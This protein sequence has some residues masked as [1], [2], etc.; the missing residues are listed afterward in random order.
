MNRLVGCLL[1]GLV[2]VSALTQAEEVR[3]WQRL[4]LAISLVVGQERVIF[5][6]QP[7]RVGLPAPL[8]GRLRVQSAGGALYLLA[9]ETL[10]PTRLQVQLVESGEV[11][12]LDIAAEP[13]AQPL[14]PVRIAL[15]DTTMVA[16]DAPTVSAPTPVPVALVRYAAQQ[17]YAPLR[18]VEPLPGVRPVRL[19]LSGKLATLMPTD[20]LIAT[21]LMAWRLEDFW[22]TAVLLR[23]RTART[24]PLDPRR[25]Q[26][27]LY[28]TS[29][30]HYYLGAQGTAED[31]SV[32]YLVSRGGGLEQAL[33]TPPLTEVDDER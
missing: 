4:P 21:P 2:S 22:V 31:T 32:A 6:D 20:S 15:A 28:A 8:A 12:L 7:I 23:N 9:S 17:L 3:Q 29:F 27:R 30:Q 14:E 13:G 33:F 24:V 19:R 1:L 10:A 18:T 11:L 5:V 25:V 16:T 26:A